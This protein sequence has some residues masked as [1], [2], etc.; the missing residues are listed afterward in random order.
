MSIEDTKFPEKGVRWTSTLEWYDNLNDSHT[1]F[2][3]IQSYFNVYFTIKSPVKTTLAA[4]L[5]GATNAGEY[6]FYDANAIGG[7]RGFSRP[8]TVRG[9]HRDRFSGRSSIYQ[10]TEIRMHLA[11]VPFYYL[12]F[13]FGISAHHD[14]G[15]VWAD[16]EDSDKLHSGTGGGI[17]FGPLE[18]WVFTIS[19]T[20]AEEDEMYNANLGFLF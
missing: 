11:R 12:P 3:L 20:K 16:G 6:E 17:W 14:I 19:Y 2:A 8:G 10:N 7:N 9:Y 15:R 5:G 18:R 1:K 13:T 4:R